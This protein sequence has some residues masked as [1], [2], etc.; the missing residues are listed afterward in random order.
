[1]S[2]P[3]AEKANWSVRGLAPTWCVEFG[4]LSCWRAR[5]DQRRAWGSG[6]WWAWVVV[7][8]RNVV[9]VGGNF[10]SWAAC[11]GEPSDGDFDTGEL[12]EDA[13]LLVAA[14]EDDALRGDATP[15]PGLAGRAAGMGP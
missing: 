6:G 13:P 3:Y 10:L 14:T 11:E 12:S 4:A 1:M 9:G 5:F 15:A 8:L 2:C 7:A